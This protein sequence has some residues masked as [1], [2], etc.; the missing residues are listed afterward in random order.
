MPAGQLST[1]SRK[2]STLPAFLNFA[3]SVTGLKSDACAPFGP[4]LSW[5]FVA[6]I[7]E[8]TSTVISLGTLNAFP[9]GGLG[10]GS[11][12]ILMPHCGMSAPARH[13]SICA[14]TLTA[15]PNENSSAQRS[16]IMQHTP[17]A[18]S[19]RQSLGQR[20]FSAT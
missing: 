10:G 18:D 7:R 6:L 2:R 13:G 20:A 16:R 5:T 8:G 3:A 14:Q 19:N 12:A 17:L 15:P 11:S 9:S 4:E 1:L